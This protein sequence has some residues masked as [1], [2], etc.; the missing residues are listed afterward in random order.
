[1]LIPFKNNLIFWNSFM[2]SVTYVLLPDYYTCLR[3]LFMCLC[4][5]MC[6]KTH[7]KSMIH[8]CS[9]RAFEVQGNK[10]SKTIKKQ[11]WKCNPVC[12]SEPYNNS[13][14]WPWVISHC[15]ISQSIV[16]FSSSFQFSMSCSHQEIIILKLP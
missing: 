3:R 10:K 5:C 11:K 7:K 13:A 14:M 2:N 6:T 9:T 4:V 16:L 1:M 12:R 15:D 8:M